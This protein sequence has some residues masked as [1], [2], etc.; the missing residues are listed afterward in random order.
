MKIT[1]K[2]TRRPPRTYPRLRGQA[3]ELASKFIAEEVRS[4]L[5]RK[6]A[7]AVGIS[8]ARAA[9]TKTRLNRII[10]RYL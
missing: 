3:R 4:G 7:I 2:K 9:E 5:P 8:R 6:Q 10:A 1:S